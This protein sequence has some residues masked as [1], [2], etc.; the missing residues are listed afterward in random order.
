MVLN[1]DEKAVLK[2]HKR[3][4]ALLDRAD[5]PR[6]QRE[7]LAPVIDNMSW[8]RAKLDETRELMQTAKVVCKYDHGGGQSGIKENPLFKGYSNLF[9]TYM[10]AVEKF[11]SYLPKELQEEASGDGLNVLEQV[12]R[13]KKVSA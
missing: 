3:L 8:M 5:V 4:E 9:R 6:Q 11:S 12:I 2:E 10:I 7:V 13:M 1:M